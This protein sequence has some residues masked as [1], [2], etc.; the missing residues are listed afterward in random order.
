VSRGTAR[1]EACCFERGADG[2]QRT[3]QFLVIDSADRGRP[4][5]GAHQAEQ[6]SQGG[7]LACTVGAEEP[8]HCA[9]LDRESE[10]AHGLDGAESLRQPPYLDGCSIR[11]I[12]TITIP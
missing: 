7:R 8:C 3:V 9:R 11:H 6:H 12:T 4:L 2:G 5:T 1:V 10:A